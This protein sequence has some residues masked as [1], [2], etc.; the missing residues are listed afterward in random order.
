MSKRKVTRSRGVVRQLI[1]SGLLEAYRLD[2]AAVVAFTLIGVSV[3]KLSPNLLWAYAGVVLL[4]AV[5]ALGKAA[6]VKPPA[7]TD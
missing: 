6:A 1:S 5:I 7:R 3:Y 4:L 2:A